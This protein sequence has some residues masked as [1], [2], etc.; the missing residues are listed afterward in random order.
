MQL[1]KQPHLF[2][3]LSTA[4]MAL[5]SGIYTITSKLEDFPVG[6]N[7]REDRSLLPKR[8]VI[9]PKGIEDPKVH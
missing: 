5:E 7:P 2:S 8:V 4:I 6:R 3:L 9:L 1:R